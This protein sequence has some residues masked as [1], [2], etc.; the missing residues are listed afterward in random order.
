MKTRKILTFLLI[1]VFIVHLL[2]VGPANAMQIF[3]QVEVPGG[4]R[5]I[6]LE[7]EPGDSIDNIKGKIEDKEGIPPA[8]QHLYFGDILLEDGHTLADYNVQKESYLFLVILPAASAAEADL[9]GDGALTIADVTY[10]LG[11]LSE[12]SD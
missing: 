2:P 12:S 5:T 11:L 3:V 1:T 6:T 8:R 9:D 7:V 4:L 10:L